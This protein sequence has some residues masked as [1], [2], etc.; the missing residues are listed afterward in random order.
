MQT[1]VSVLIGFLL[2]GITV[3]MLMR[4]SEWRA[5]RPDERDMQ[6]RGAVRA[7]VRHLRVHGTLNLSQ[8]ERMMDINGVTALRYLD[9]MVRDGILKVQG[10]RGAGAFYTRS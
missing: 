1:V 7:A 3:G 9:R 4:L 2:G 8:L 5:L 6:Y 10:H